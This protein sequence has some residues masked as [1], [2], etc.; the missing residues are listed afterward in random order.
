MGQT[1]STSCHPTAPLSSE[2][3]LTNNGQW[4]IIS[5]FTPRIHRDYTE[6]TPR[7]H[8]DYTEIT[9]RLHRD[10]STCQ[11]EGRRCLILS[12]A[13]LRYSKWSMKVP[14]FAQEVPK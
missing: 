11:F 4:C 6:I 7:L 2:M 12:K 1:D 13:V 5:T 10:Y 3:K 8:R 14:Y 9:P